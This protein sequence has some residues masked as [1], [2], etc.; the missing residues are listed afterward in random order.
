MVALV[1]L[2]VIVEPL[3]DDERDPIRERVAFSLG[4]EVEVDARQALV[5]LRQRYPLS[6]SVTL[7]QAFTTERGSVFTS[8]PAI[9]AVTSAKSSAASLAAY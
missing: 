7:I 9:A 2:A 1:W 3:K 6:D 8:P 5:R 4:P